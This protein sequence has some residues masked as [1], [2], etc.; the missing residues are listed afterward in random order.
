MESVKQLT[1]QMG[2]CHTSIVELRDGT[3]MAASSLL[4]HRQKFGN[5]MKSVYDD[6][7]VIVF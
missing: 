3:V 5:H 6:K 2:K 1:W 7:F 4:C